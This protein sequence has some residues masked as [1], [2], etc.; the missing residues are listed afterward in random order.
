MKILIVEDDN[1]SR[2]YIHKILSDYGK[3][4]L[5]V[6]GIEAIEAFLMALDENEPY[7]L[8]CI[9]IMMPKVNGLKAIKITKDIERQKGVKGNNRTKIVVI[10]ALTDKSLIEQ[11]MQY[12]YD[13]YIVKPYDVDEVINTLQELN[14]IK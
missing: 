6:D 11:C 2:R 10:S 3:C 1:D 8:L 9:D 13:R 5:T 12:G 14:L 4:D 7:D